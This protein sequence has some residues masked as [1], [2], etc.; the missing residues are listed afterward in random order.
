MYRQELEELGIMVKG[1]AGMTKNKMPK[2]LTRAQK[3]IRSLFIG[4]P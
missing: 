2:M 3:E 1:N 4:K